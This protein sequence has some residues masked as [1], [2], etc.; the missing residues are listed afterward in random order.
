MNLESEKKV[1]L[2]NTVIGGPTLQICV[3][4]MAPNKTGLLKEAQTALKHKP[5]L[6]EWRADAFASGIDRDTCLDALTALRGVIRNIPLIF[7]YRRHRE[8]GF[9]KISVDKREGLILSAIQSGHADMIDIELSNDEVFI[10]NIQKATND[11]GLQLILS[12][13][14]FKVTPKPEYI[15]D[16]LLQAQN[17]GADI[18]KVAVMPQN[19]E[20]VLTLMNAALKA[21][22]GGLNIPMIAISMG[23]LGTL[24]R[25][26]GKFFG[27][28]ISFA[29][30]QTSSAPGQMPIHELRQAMTILYQ[31]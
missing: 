20:D 5:D 21:R 24:T 1:S 14:N 7:T 23:P 30:S 13:H 6:L 3:P 2:R 25:L 29:S 12:Y 15:I 4:L 8:G 11:S 16:T 27:S 22:K 31:I 9:A 18:A 19:F 26:A 17:S 28:D 10:Q